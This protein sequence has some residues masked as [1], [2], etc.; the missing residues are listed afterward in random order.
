M[1]KERSLQEIIKLFNRLANDPTSKCLE[2][3]NFSE[4]LR[5]YVHNPSNDAKLQ[6][7]MILKCKELECKLILLDKYIR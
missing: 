7:S 5:L 6:I 3:S 2:Y 4:C 1:S